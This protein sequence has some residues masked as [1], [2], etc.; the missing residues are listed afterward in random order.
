MNKYSLY[1]TFP[2]YYWFIQKNIIM[3]DTNAEPWDVKITVSHF[4][5]LYCDAFV[6]QN[7]SFVLLLFL[8]L[9]MKNFCYIWRYF[10]LGTVKKI[11]IKWWKICH[12]KSL[13]TAAM[14]EKLKTFMLFLFFLTRNKGRFFTHLQHHL[15]HFYYQNS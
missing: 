8:L 1:A 4:V 6:T 12:K 7:L 13:K 2:S 11:I 10:I 14:I 3:Y 15:F 5:P 9:Y